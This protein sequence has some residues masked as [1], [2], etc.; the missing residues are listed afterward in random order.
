M[1]YTNPQDHFSQSEARDV[2]GHCQGREVED[3]RRC[4]TEVNGCSRRYS[5]SL[6]PD[7]VGPR[8]WGC[9]SQATCP[10]QTRSSWGA[11]FWLLRPR[12]ERWFME[13]GG[14]YRILGAE[15]L[16]SPRGESSMEERAKNGRGPDPSSRLL[17][18]EW[19]RYLSTLSQTIAG[20]YGVLLQASKVK[21]SGPPEPLAMSDCRQSHCFLHEGLRRVSVYPT[22]CLAMRNPHVHAL[23]TRAMKV[24]AFVS[25]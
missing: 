22:R 21:A 23:A 4:R 3:G 12:L 25:T 18:L 13:R 10:T 8:R 16:G 19:F 2:R 1:L 17:P 7:M 11:V 5:R 14:A 9:K 6:K 15:S 20:I 24:T